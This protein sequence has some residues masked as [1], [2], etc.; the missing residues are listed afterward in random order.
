MITREESLERV[1]RHVKN[2]NLVKHMI[3]VSAIMRGVADRLGEDSELWG[4]VGMLRDI[5]Y[6]G[7]VPRDD[8]A[9]SS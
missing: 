8:E 9:A 1:R 6:E 4:A 2:E 5:D 3:A 7:P